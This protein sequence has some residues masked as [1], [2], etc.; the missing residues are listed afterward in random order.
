M[1]RAHQIHLSI[2]SEI[3]S[4]LNHIL[5]HPNHV[6]A[7]GTVSVTEQQLGRLLVTLLKYFP[8]SSF[9]TSRTFSF[10]SL[11][12]VYSFSLGFFSS[13]SLYTPSLTWEERSWTSLCSPRGFDKVL[14]AKDG[15]KL[16][17][18]LTHGPGE[19]RRGQ[20]LSEA[21]LH[22]HILLFLLDALFRLF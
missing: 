12:S 9:F 6:F 8:C 10:L 14:T 1:H 5:A 19:S 21:L 18:T 3:V 22:L 17:D 16:Q 20:F 4:L 11:S 15:G 13:L 2:K 7:A